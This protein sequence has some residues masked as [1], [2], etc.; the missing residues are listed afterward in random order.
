MTGSWRETADVLLESPLPGDERLD[1]AP[2]QEQARQE[3]AEPYENGREV[4]PFQRE[5][6]FSAISRL[7]NK[8]APGLDLMQSE[9]IK[10][11][12]DEMMQ[13]LYYSLN[14]CLEQKRFPI[15]WKRADLV[16]LRKAGPGVAGS[17]R[18]ICL[19]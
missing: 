8:K 6:I 4:P 7:R 18:P 14:K 5:E 15:I 16:I 19:E 17:Y 2:E 1:K 12:R 9:V 10:S 13:D 11:L 3:I